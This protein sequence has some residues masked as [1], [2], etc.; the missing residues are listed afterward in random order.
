MHQIPRRLKPP[1]PKFDRAR[2]TSPHSATGASSTDRLHVRSVSAAHGTDNEEEEI[3][4]PHRG[5][6]SRS[7]NATAPLPLQLAAG[8]INDDHSALS[9]TTPIPVTVLQQAPELPVSSPAPVEPQLRPSEEALLPLNA[10]HGMCDHID[11]W[12]DSVTAE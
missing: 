3:F 8:S 12:C 2:S 1:L 5:H 6:S 4:V 7:M 11:H 10:G 9:S